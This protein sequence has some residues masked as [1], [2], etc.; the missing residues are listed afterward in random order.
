MHNL[1]QSDPTADHSPILPP[2]V[3]RI[4]SDRASDDAIFVADGGSATVYLARYMR[5]HGKRRMLG[6]FNHGAISAGVGM[7]MGASCAGP[8]RQVWLLAG[9]GSFGMM[10]QDVITAKAFGWP[11]K[12]VVF[13]NQEFDFV[14]MEMQ[15][16][17]IPIDPAATRVLN[18]DFAAFAKAN[19]IGCA[20]ATRP[21][22]MIAA[23][24]QA[25]A[26]DGPF[27]IDAKVQAGLLCMPPHIAATQAYGFGMSTIKEALLGLAGDH[28]QWANW[29]NEFR[30]N[31]LD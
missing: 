21:S 7:A 4:I 3:A 18:M 15:V 16:A 20:V 29:E 26:Y 27:L 8:K 31:L 2:V 13:D 9:D 12:I 11:I 24:E 6:S 10:P 25:L 14:R 28:E 17:G 19:G 5:L 30:A 1:H 22:E 23:V